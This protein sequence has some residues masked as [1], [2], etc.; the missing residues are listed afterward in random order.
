MIFINIVAQFRELT[1]KFLDAYAQFW[2]VT[3]RV[4]FGIKLGLLVT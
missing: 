2:K 4:R 1:T 3:F